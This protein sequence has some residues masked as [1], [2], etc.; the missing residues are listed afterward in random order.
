MRNIFKHTLIIDFEA[1]PNGDIFHVGAVFNGRTFEKKDIKDS[2]AVLKELSVFSSGADYVLGHN[3]INHD[4]AL[5]KEVLPDASILHLPV[6]DTL[7]LS[8]LAFPENPYHKLIKNYKLIK[9]SKNNPVADAN[10]AWNVFED[11]VAAF[12]VLNQSDP[13]LILFYTFAFEPFSSKDQKLRV[14]GIFDLFKAL[15][16]SVP[17]TDK[18]KQIFIEVCQGKICS[19]AFETIW[20]GF[21][22]HPQKRP[23]LA[24]A[25]S[26]LRVSGG[27]S[28][29][30]PWVK[31]EFPQISD[32]ITKL[33]YACGSKDCEYCRENNDSEKLLKKYFGFDKYRRLPDGRK[34]QKEIIDSNLGGNSLLGILPTGGGKSICYQIPALHRYHRTG[35]LT[36][37]ISPLK[38]LM[39]DQVDNLNKTTGMESAGA[40]NGSLTLP[41][42][43]E[44][45]EKVRL[46]DI[47]V[48]YI[49]PEQLRNFSV[50]ELISSRDV[51][52]WIFD[53]AH[54]LSKW[55]HDFRPDYLN[56]ADFI[57]EQNRGSKR[58]PLINA[59]TATAKKD[60]IEEICCHFTEKLDLDLVSFISG[61]QR[62][63]LSFQV[64]PVTTAEKHDVIFNCLKESVS[65]GD[66]SAIVYCAT[67]KK[68]EE[69]SEFLNEKAIASQAFH[70]GRSEPD[71]RNI[72]DD[73]VAGKI[74]V[75]C[76]TNAFGM[77]I[78]KKDIRLVIHADIPGSLENYLQEAGRA[79]RDTAPADCILLYEQEDIE[80]QFSLNAYSKLSLKDIKKILGVL[81]KKGAKTPEI[82]ITPGEIMRLIGYSNFAED[83]GRARIGVSW[84]ER[85]GFLK[86]SFNQ[87]LFFKGKPL[88]KDM[89][90]A[91]EKIAALNLSKI[92]AMV[93][94]TILLTLFN[95]EKDSILSA[96]T[97]CAS[98]GR[99]ENLPDEYLDSR[100]V[101]G[102]LSRMADI[103]LIKEGV[104]M[105]AFVKPKGQDNSGKLLESFIQIETQMLEIMAQLSPNAGISQD[106]PDVIHL[107]LMSQRLKD[108]GFDQVNTDVVAKI[109]QALANDKGENQGK[110]LKIA[111]RKGAEQQMIYV[112]FSWQKIKKRMQL[113]HN[114]SRLCLNAIICALP[115]PLQQGRAQVMSE[116]FLSHIIKQMQS[117]VFLSGYRG[118]NKILI[119]RSLLFMHDMKVITLQNGLGVF[120]QAMTLTMLPESRKR[121]YTQGDYEPLSH[122]Y[123]QKNVQ[124]HVMEKYA[125]LGLEKIKTAL[126]FV[127]D[128]FSSSYDFFIQQHF[129]K[130]KTLIQTAMTAEAYKQIIQSL[131]NH[132]Q[133]AIVAAPPEKNI[134]VLAGPGSG[135]TKTIVHRCA[136]LIKAKSVDPSSILVLCFNH[137]AMIELRKRI[138]TL[139]GSRASF[140]TAMTYHGFAMRLTGRSFLENKK[141]IENKKGLEKEKGQNPGKNAIGFDT[142]IDEAI[143][144]LNG[145]RE[146][147][148]IERSEARE[149]LLAQYRYILVDE[150]Q[151]IDDRQYQFISALTGRLEQD[152]DTRISIMAVGDDDQSIYGFRNANVRFIKQFQ[153]DYE[154]KTFYLVENYR[155]SYPMIQASN[156][157]IALNKNRMK[158][159]SPCRINEKRKSQ[160]Q[161]AC[162]IENS[163]LVQIVQVKDMASQAGFVARKIKQLMTDDPDM[164]LHD[165]AV[166]SRQGMGYPSLVSVRMALAKE[167]IQFCYSIK[168]GSGFPLFRIRE[169][170]MF[171][172]YLEDH[173]KESRTPCDLKQEVLEQFKQKNTWTSQVGQILESWCDINSDMEISIARA[174][175]FALETLLEEKQEHKT[176]TGVFLGT[177]HSVKGMEFSFVFILDGR[178]K[179]KDIEEERR[180]FYVAM[181]R[182]IKTAYIFQIQDSSNPHVRFLEQ[183]EFAHIITAEQSDIDGFNEELTVSILGMEDLFLSYAGLF[184]EDH[185]IHKTLSTLSPME[186]ISLIEKKNHIY[187]ENKHH[188][189]IARLSNKGKAKWH[190][191]T[192]TILHARVLGIIRRQQT[193]GEDYDGKREKIGTWELP[194]VEILHKKLEAKSNNFLETTLN[195]QNAP[196]ESVI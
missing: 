111:G 110:S 193:D 129:P 140:V 149:V 47:G 123:A 176:G 45:M 76:A 73:F 66:S 143:E 127:S 81:K 14:T 196:G 115:K 64:W 184:S 11:Q 36:V 56:V 147:A 6:I 20:D 179:Q 186:K 99:I 166:V 121:Q 178:W 69:L 98:L 38:A 106:T 117:D 27:N 26:W 15:S 113:R 136:W 152:R 164:K 133:E 25:L 46:G 77:G 183:N 16:K 72:Q 94:R 173:K 156:A 125:R 95:A 157:F 58:P 122:H 52:C 114:C 17:D 68:T 180:L 43:G 87:T 175:D 8:P 138:R 109:L 169:I 54:C 82:V 151:D 9:N 141:G 134:L 75:I 91:E 89:K 162:K 83:D 5:L 135:K 41:E 130:E 116:F 63:N 33:R 3:I 190:N 24:Y 32:M 150:Y 131:E 1:V 22:D 187:I 144:I 37:V 12:S 59:F 181:T 112:K 158:T 29:I 42:R 84:L 88:V 35:E 145:K 119:E 120:R 124:V 165:I 128:Y 34:L 97:I 192:Q 155:S 40:I 195:H 102:L 19:T 92:M 21:C 174:K 10:L 103:G 85:K 44:V 30:P 185:E 118:D 90:E 67:R 2:K 107:R 80:N 104:L 167:E 153:Q 142:I 49:S 188:Q 146:I 28:V 51:G 132:I 168:N 172:Q 61:V 31:H 161:E 57:L 194:I 182:S 55:G 170:Q 191:Q 23:V 108:K 78:D 126:G 101:I 53:E 4:L 163:G 154:A 18:A 148:G 93:F 171:L 74:P 13:G 159:G 100:F 62:E 70:A 137:Q 65:D 79:G 7:Y 48:L 71:K 39:K 160:E 189:I 177:A 60:V 50:A 139:T 105:T 96:D 86:R